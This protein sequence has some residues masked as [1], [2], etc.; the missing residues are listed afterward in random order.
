MSDS[1][2]QKVMDFAYDKFETNLNWDIEG[3]YSNISTI[4]RNACIIGN[5]NYQVCNGGF[6]QWM[7]NGYG[8]ASKPYIVN[9]LNSIE[10]DTAEKVN[11]L[12]R[13]FSKS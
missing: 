9:I 11:K 7:G 8:P 12:S 13:M 10:T 5:L 6:T 1:Y 3:F 2:I 4:E